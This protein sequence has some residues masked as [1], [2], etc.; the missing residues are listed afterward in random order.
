MSP[1]RGFGL[2]ELLLAIVLTGLIGMVGI[3]VLLLQRR[4]ARVQTDRAQM[5]ANV[6]AG[7]LFLQ[8][9]LR[10]LGGDD[11]GPD[12]Q[13]A[14]PE[15]LAYRAMRG[16]GLLCGVSAASVSLDTAFS[17]GFRQPQAGRDSLL[18][19]VEGDSTTDQDDRWGH[20]PILGT[21]S[22]NCS[23]RGA[24]VIAT[25]IDTAAYPLASI[26]VPAPARFFEIMQLKLY[27]SGGEW[28][29]GG[30][31]ISAGET[32]QPIL[33]PLSAQWFRPVIPGLDWRLP[34][35]ARGGPVHP[36]LAARRE[37]WAG[38]QSRP[39]DC[40]PEPI[41]MARVLSRRGFALPFTL[42]LLVVLGVLTAAGFLLVRLDRQSGL[43][44]LHAVRASEAAEAGLAEVTS[45]WN[46]S[47]YDTLS[48]GSG[49]TLPRRNLGGGRF[50]DAPGSP[51]LP[52]RSS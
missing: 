32:L 37:R 52:G 18:L 45:G 42:G 34:R 36:A 25:M 49:L 29:L 44:A 2:V 33:G 21:G 51:G 27:Q 3:R 30:R 26:L 28:W 15:S 24:I 14:A 40:A 38:G 31:S 19:F 22:G 9:E 12:L 1:R 41:A 17:Y 4:T 10:E 23:G 7:L 8:S 5:Q 43:N 6:R 39:G 50:Y 35:T 20:F 48:A 16:G 11:T 13:V 47:L 46:H